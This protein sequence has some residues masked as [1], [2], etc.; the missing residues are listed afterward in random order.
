MENGMGT[1]A[2]PLRR[3][4]TRKKRWRW[5]FSDYVLF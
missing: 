1:A 2:F 5:F 4:L 3:F